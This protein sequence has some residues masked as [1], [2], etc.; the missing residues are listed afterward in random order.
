MSKQ[1]TSAGTVIVA[2]ALG[3]LAGASLALLYAPVTGDEARR[4]LGEKARQGRQRAEAAARQGGDL[5]R[6]QR[7]RMAEAI[8]RGVEAFKRTRKESL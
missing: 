8:D 2:F 3:A 4:T 1:G 7:E 5:L 6:R